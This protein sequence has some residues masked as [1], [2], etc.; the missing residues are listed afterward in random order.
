MNDLEKI[1]AAQAI[2]NHFIALDMINVHYLWDIQ[3]LKS[4]MVRQ[5]YFVGRMAGT[6]SEMAI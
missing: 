4:Y 2:A 1:L 3:Q 5:W 6:F